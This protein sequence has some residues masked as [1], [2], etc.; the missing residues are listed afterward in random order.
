MTR[1]LTKTI[2]VA[3]AAALTMGGASA[4]SASEDSPVDA[5]VFVTKVD[6]LSPDFTMGVDVSSYLSLIES[7]VRFRDADGRRADL[8]EVLAD[9]GVTDVRLRVWNDPFHSDTGQGY[10]GGNVDVERAVEMGRRATEAG[11]GVLVDFH[12]SDFWADPAKQKAPK[13]WAAL[14]LNEKAGATATYTAASLRA[15]AEAGV[16]VRM[17]QV[18][19]ETNNGVAGETGWPAMSRIFQAG[20]EAVRDVFPDALVALHFTNPEQGRYPD[21]AAQLDANG[22]DYDVFASSYYPY[23]HGT[24]EHLTTE[25]STIARDHGKKVMVAE[26]SWAHT[27][28]DGDGH[29]NVIDLASEATQ[30]PISVQGQARALRD[31]IAAVDAV[32]GDAGI[33]VY[34]WEPA[35]L[36]VGPASELERNRRLWERDGSGW[37][38]SAAAEY[39][40]D[41]AG[42][43][44]GGSAW[45]N[46]ALFDAAGRPL[47]SLATFEYVYT[48][49][50]TE[51]AIESY[52]PVS[53]TVTDAADI[54]LP[55]T[56][57]LRYNDLSSEEVP[58]AWSDALTWIT[59]PGSYVVSGV[60]GGATDVSAS[61][62]VSDNALRDPDFEEQDADAWTVTG[63]GGAIE[64][65]ADATSGTYAF[66]FWSDAAYS[67]SVSQTV[68]GLPAGEYAL[69][70]VA[71]GGSFTSGTAT[72]RAET[73]AGTVDAPLQLTGWG[74]F[75]AAE[76]P[77]TVG[78][79]GEVV[80]TAALAEANAGTWGVFDEF[81][82]TAVAGSGADVT[83]LTALVERAEGLDASRYTAGSVR[84]LT[85]AIAKARIVLGATTP[86]AAQVDAASALVQD[87]IDGLVRPFRKVGEPKITGSATV[88]KTVSA[89]LSVSPRPTTTTYQWLR[90]GEPIAGATRSTYRVGREDAGDALTVAVTVGL[91]GYETV[92]V[93]SDPVTVRSAP[94][95]GPKK[96]RG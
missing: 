57:T 38:T 70:A 49:A 51:R 36:P 81:S 22:V 67:T 25:L 96:P 30:Y 29:G 9:H 1:K 31:V 66:K 41:D 32:E 10:G 88:G 46:Q 85:S 54:D 28:E 90:N 94:G 33:G 76:V 92:T 84:T 83:Q 61:I 95:N 79:D 35:W 59:G 69:R 20:S 45:D 12:Y 8:F 23:W 52:D 87:A 21:I 68:T 64:W 19:N 55:D 5:G 72:L 53:L 6:G 7:G 3:I 80:V 48:G 65:S 82:L 91:R 75:N 17:V 56:V 63:S 18:G 71:H 44:Y 34:Y 27:L 74:S 13:A 89:K 24:V 62:T 47:E 26:T 60:A 40:P 4:A 58:V 42:E 78:D 15:F 50:V 16:D 86:T 11:L 77:V 39:D 93:V 73:A 14:D 2:S 43:Y 37:A